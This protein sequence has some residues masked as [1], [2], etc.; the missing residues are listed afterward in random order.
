MVVQN[1]ENGFGVFKLMEIVPCSS[2][3]W[4]FV[5][6]LRN[7]LSDG[8][9][10]QEEISEGTHRGF[11]V[12][13]Y[14]NYRICLIEKEP[15]GFIGHVKLDIRVATHP[16]HQGKGVAK[17]MLTKFMKDFP[18]AAAQVKIENKSSLSLFE[19]CGFEVSY[20]GL[21]QC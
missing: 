4:E 6:S 21:K 1:E 9:F 19:S 12:K 5:R 10:S 14:N 8:F 11:M 18:A 2:E 15:V 7:D 16:D 3:Y 20:Y 13:H 17:F